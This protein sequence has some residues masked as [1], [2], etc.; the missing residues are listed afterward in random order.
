[1][2]PEHPEAVPGAAAYGDD[3]LGVDDHPP[4]FLY[5]QACLSDEFFGALDRDGDLLAVRQHE[6]DFP[7]PAGGVQSQK[8]RLKRRKKPTSEAR[9]AIFR[10]K[11]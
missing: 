5:R 9:R 7:S 2:V 10:R 6:L 8:R 11:T 4:R 3:V 1:M